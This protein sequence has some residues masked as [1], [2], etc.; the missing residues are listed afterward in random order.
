MRR[1]EGEERIVSVTTHFTDMINGT[2]SIPG[3]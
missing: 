3:A 2:L 1:E